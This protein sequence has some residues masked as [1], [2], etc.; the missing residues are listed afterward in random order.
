MTEQ[1][2]NEAIEYA[3]SGHARGFAAKSALQV[4]AKA[5]R[6]RAE[7]LAVLEELVEMDNDMDDPEWR[8]A[9]AAI[10]KAKGGANG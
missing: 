2:I 8:P 1:A 10:A 5:A 3:E 4:L 6:E 7:L 9:R